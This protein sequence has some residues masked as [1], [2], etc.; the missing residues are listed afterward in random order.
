[1][2]YK[3]INKHPF[4]YETSGKGETLLFIHGLGSSTLDWEYQLAHF[5]KNYK[6]IALDLKGHGKTGSVDGA[7]SIKGFANDVAV[8]LEEETQPITI[9]G[10]SMGGMVSFQLAV[11]YPQ[12]V[13]QLII[14][15]S[16]AEIPMDN[17]YIR[18]QVRIRKLVPSLLGMKATGKMIANKVFPHKHQKDLRKLIISRWQKNSIKDYVKSVKASAGWRIIDKL[19]TI[20]CPV[21][22]V[23]AEFDYI[24]NDEK[25]VYTKLIPK[26]E[27]VL[28]KGLRHAV[29]ME[30]PKALNAV[31]D[32]FLKA[33]K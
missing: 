11:D 13:K 3:T 20:T 24:S 15:N 28:M 9:I 21:L 2:P 12:L 16:F 29:S 7:Y 8:F 22:V 10:I 27:F 4:Y 26:G 6:V 19:H 32:D 25:M 23:G 17:R 30:D 33:I 14:I 1:M 18:N 5:S 31:I